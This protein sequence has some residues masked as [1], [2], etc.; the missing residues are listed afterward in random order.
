MQIIEMDNG[1]ISVWLGDCSAH[2]PK[3]QTENVKKLIE[4]AKAIGAAEAKAN[5]RAALGVD[6]AIE[7][8]SQCIYHNLAP[9]GYS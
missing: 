5:I 6:E 3:S 7:Y 1:A 9:G 2:F 8:E 4:A